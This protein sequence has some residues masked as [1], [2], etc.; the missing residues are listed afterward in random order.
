[1][2]HL[3]T[4]HLYLYMN[5]SRVVW[6]VVLRGALPAQRWMAVMLAGALQLA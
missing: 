2:A 5:T 3:D 6:L 1:M 4:C